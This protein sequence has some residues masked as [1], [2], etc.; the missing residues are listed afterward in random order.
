M[1]DVD[2]ALNIYIYFFFFSGDY[3]YIYKISKKKLIWKI[4]YKCINLTCEIKIQY[5]K[6][7]SEQLLSDIKAGLGDR[8][9]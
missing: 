9:T 5:S 8:R 3:I 4:L 6:Q 2:T 7:I 1:R